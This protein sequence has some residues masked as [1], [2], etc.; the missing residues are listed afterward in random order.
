MSDITAEQFESLP[1]FLTGQY[2]KVS[3]GDLVSYRHSSDIKASKLK[4]SLNSLDSKLK[5][6]DS[7]LTEYTSK[8]AERSAD[9]ERKAFEKLKSEGKVDEIIADYDKRN[10]ESKAQYEAR[11]EKLMSGMKSEK[12]NAIVSDLA[13]MATDKG[14]KAFKRL[15]ADRVDYDPETGKTIY[16]DEAGRATSLDYE[17]F[18]AEI[19][20]DDTFESLLRAT[21]STSGGLDVNGSGSVGGTGSVPRTF[22][23]CKGNKTLEAA[24]FNKQMGL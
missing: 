2:E 4:E 22:E 1:E 10:N 8:E 21:V 13:A 23:E 12:R 11:I 18:K 15:I 3:E 5:E 20:K 24:F 14:S 19:Q 9:A 6:K 17:G 16:L 7:A